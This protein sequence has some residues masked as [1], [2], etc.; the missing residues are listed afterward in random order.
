MSKDEVWKFIFFFHTN[1]PKHFFTYFSRLRK[2]PENNFILFHHFKNQTFRS[3]IAL[4][5]CAINAR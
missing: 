5:A 4:N 1:R 3:Q 2:N